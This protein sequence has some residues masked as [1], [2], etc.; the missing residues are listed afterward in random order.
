MSA[1]PCKRGLPFLAFQFGV[2]LLHKLAQLVGKVKQAFPLLDAEGDGHSLQAVEADAAFAAN[3][4]VQRA[5]LGGLVGKLLCGLID[6]QYSGRHLSEDTLFL[7][8]GSPETAPPG[9]PHKGGGGFKTTMLAK[10]D[11]IRQPPPWENHNASRTR[12]G[13]PFAATPCASRGLGEAE[14]VLRGVAS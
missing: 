3:L 11:G 8:T 6:R 10:C 5:P 2:V 12:T 1:P 4:A 14:P 9:R 13:N 7:H